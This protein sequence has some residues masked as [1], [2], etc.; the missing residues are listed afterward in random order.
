MVLPKIMQIVKGK[1]EVFVDCGAV[2]GYDVFKAIALGATAVS[3]G[4]V[5]MPPLTENGA[6]GVAKTVRDMTAQL[7]GIM[8]RTCA[9]DIT[10]IDSSMIWKK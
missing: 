10:Q 1:M 7:A 2:S 3:A 5:M 9:H 6:D 4:R 8:A